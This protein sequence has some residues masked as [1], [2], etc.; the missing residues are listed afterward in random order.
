L[1]WRRRV[2]PV[3]LALP[4][5]T[6]ALVRVGACVEAPQP[7]GGLGTV[8][9]PSRSG[10]AEAILHCVAAGAFDHAG[11]DQ[12]PR[13]TASMT[14]KWRS[15]NAVTALTNSGSAGVASE[16]SRPRFS[17]LSREEHQGAGT[18]PRAPNGLP[19]ATAS[20]TTHPSAGEGALRATPLARSAACSVLKSL[21]SRGNQTD[22]RSSQCRRLEL[23]KLTSTGQSRDAGSNRRPAPREAET[24]GKDA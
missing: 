8:Q 2:I 4:A 11:R 10:D 16:T 19:A 7:E 20:L 23:V 5:E 15:Q 17:I 6:H 24:S 14:G 1:S 22:C 13:M 3:G 18:Q 12:D 9:V 21:F